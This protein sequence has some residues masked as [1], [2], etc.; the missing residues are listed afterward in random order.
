M[1]GARLASGQEL[2]GV[3][4]DEVC[5]SLADD[6]K[7]YQAYLENPILRQQVELYKQKLELKDQESGIKD[8]MIALEQKRGDIYKQAF[9]SGKEL[10]DRALK[11]AEVSKKSSFD[12]LGIIGVVAIVA[13]AVVSIL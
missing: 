7:L 13:A 9:E 8:Q 4:G 11:L 12:I 3:P 1:P 5:H 10:T 2:I 6:Q